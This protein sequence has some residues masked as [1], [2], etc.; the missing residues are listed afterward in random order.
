MMHIGQ[1]IQE[2]LKEKGKT[3]VWFASMLSCHRTNVYKIFSKKSI[4]THELERI[5][6]ILDFDFFSLYSQKLKQNKQL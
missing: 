2:T 3:V 1:L 5:C 6:K 4:D